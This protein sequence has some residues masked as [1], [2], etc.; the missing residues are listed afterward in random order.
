M[1][2]VILEDIKLKKN[3]KKPIIL[4]KKDDF[5]VEPKVEIK[6]QEESSKTKVRIMNKFIFV[7]LILSIFIGGVYWG[8]EIFQKVNITIIPKTKLITY[9]NKQ[10]S[11]LKDPKEDGVNFEMMIVSDKK[12]IDITLSQSKEV[13]IKATGSVTL[14]NGF[15]VKAEKLST[16]TFLSDGNGKTYKIN[17]NVIIP[18]YKIDNKKII[19]GQVVVNITSFLPGEIYN[20]SPA[21]FYVNSFKGTSK[22]NKI[23]G[24]LKSPLVGGASGLV[25]ELDDSNKK[26][27]EKIAQTSLKEN[28][29][30]KVKSLVP[31]GYILYPNA[32]N[33]SYKKLDSF[34]S[35][36]PE[37]QIEIEATLS[38]VLL[39]EKSL[40]EMVT[41]TSLPNISESELKEIKILGLDKLSFSFV[42]KDQLIT[43]DINL[44]PFSLS[45]DINVIWNPD[46]KLLKTK[47]IGIH[48]NDIVSVFQQDPGIESGLVK[49]F[50]P[51]QKYIPSDLS[52]IKIINQND[53]TRY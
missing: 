21:D 41:K 17:N 27:I 51:W 10:F 6:K 37:T 28:L 7:F 53:L 25:Y 22:Y 24:K 18:G 16:G 44:I 38:A 48:K 46:L 33:F 36:K 42:N 50:P 19:P 5:F 20:G 45:G 52:K 12:L 26:D 40:E 47:L 43:K 31:L 4:K 8:L 13:S 29:F 49:F 32:I 14:Y 35:K 23:Y 9:K 11:V 34:L 39:K 30:R 15:S 2:K 1:I 3:N